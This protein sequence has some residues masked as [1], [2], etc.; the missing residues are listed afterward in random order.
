MVW[1]FSGDL[2]MGESGSGVNWWERPWLV[3]NGGVCGWKV[4]CYD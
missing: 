1:W 4:D 3:W 2:V